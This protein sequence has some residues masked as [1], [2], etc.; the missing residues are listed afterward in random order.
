MFETIDIA[1]SLPDSVEEWFERIKAAFEAGEWY[2]LGFIIAE[3]L[4]KGMAVVDKWIN[5]KLRPI[6]VKWAANIAEVLNGLTDGFAWG[7]MG[8]TLADGFN[9]AFDILNTFLTTYNFK[10]LGQGIARGLNSLVNFV[11]W[12]LIGQTFANKLNAL[13]DLLYGFVHNTDWSKI[14]TSFATMVM[15][16][17]N[18]IK[19]D[20]AGKALSMV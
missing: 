3:G 2:N 6:G 9:A 7:L 11:D 17:V 8:K 14:G 5:T 16:W 12:N 18:T 19:W 20:T 13:I 10:N 4:D 1:N 15:S